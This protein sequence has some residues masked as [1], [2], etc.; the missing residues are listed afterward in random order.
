MPVQELAAEAQVVMAAGVVR[1]REA[2]ADARDPL[3]LMPRIE[4]VARNR[5]VRERDARRSGRDAV[6]ETAA[7]P[8]ITVFPS[9]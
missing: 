5:K 9:R 2:V 1:V 7:R 8:D 3:I 6:G 4:L